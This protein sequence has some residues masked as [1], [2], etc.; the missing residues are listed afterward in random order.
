ML[1]YIQGFVP[2]LTARAI[3]SHKYF[4]KSIRSF[5]DSAGRKLA[6]QAAEID[7]TKIKEQSHYASRRGDGKADGK[8]KKKYKRK[9]GEIAD[10]DVGYFGRIAASLMCHPLTV[11]TVRLVSQAEYATRNW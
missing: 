7:A 3:A 9:A 6:R 2:Y 8:E 4:E 11:L 5:L 10:P 1:W